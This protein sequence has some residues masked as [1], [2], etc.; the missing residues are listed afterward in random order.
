MSQR[1]LPPPR[2][3]PSVEAELRWSIEELSRRQGGR[4]FVVREHNRPCEPDDITRALD[5]LWN[6]GKVSRAQIECLGRYIEKGRAPNE[7]VRGELMD[8]ALWRHAIAQLGIVLRA[9]GI[10]AEK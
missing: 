3:F 1:T 5:R 10:V 2:P 4:S 7:A 8:F 6:E 9:Q